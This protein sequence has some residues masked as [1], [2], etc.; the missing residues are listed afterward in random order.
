MSLSL[1]DFIS[2]P[3]PFTISVTIESAERPVMPGK[4]LSSGYISAI[5]A[6]GVPVAPWHLRQFC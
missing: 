3:A 1:N 2:L 4:G 6:V 5:R